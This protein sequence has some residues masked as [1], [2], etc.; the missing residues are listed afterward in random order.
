MQHTYL[1]YEC[2]DSFSL[3]ASTPSTTTNTTQTLAILS[4]SSSSSDLVISSAGSQCVAF[5]LRSGNPTR[6]Y[7]K[8]G[9]RDDTTN[10]GTGRALNSNECTCLDVYCPRAGSVGTKQVVLVSTGWVDGS[11]RIFDLGN[12]DE[13]YNESSITGKILKD[14]L[15]VVN[16]LLDS[17]DNDDEDIPEPLV[18][19]GHSNSPVTCVS[20]DAEK[21]GSRLASASSDGTI[22]IWDI[23]AETGLFRLIGHHK[24]IT[25]LAFIAPKSENNDGPSSFC[26]L[27]GLIS[28]SLDG[29][30]KVWDLSG[31][32][33]TQTV[34]GHRGEIW[35]SDAVMLRD[36][37]NKQQNRWRLITGS[38]DNQLRVYDIHPPKRATLTGEEE[39]DL[40]SD[41]A[42]KT[43]SNIDD[44][45]TY[46]GSVK[47]QTNE[48]T[49][50]VRFHS[51]SKLLAVSI[52]QSKNIEIYGIRSTEESERKRVRR[53]RR[54]REKQNKK[55]SETKVV[56][57]KGILDEE[58]D[59][60]DIDDVNND[61]HD[62]IAMSPEKICAS[63]E[64]YY[65]GTVRASHKVRSFAFSPSTDRAVGSKIIISLTTNALETHSLKKKFNKEDG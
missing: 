65:L 45:L 50:L 9:Y 62:D 26:L 44:V 60:Y 29:L 25:S 31:Q 51:K 6:P 54:R 39:K 41:D 27:D 11:V 15:G 30:V 32:C 43:T 55:S 7:A 64:F 19:N 40:K 10:V 1:R 35:T 36:N 22:V 34:A 49:A 13:N 38:S 57:K 21:S 18:L 47:R 28:T 61:Q 59:D 5:D 33:C 14:G 53:L 58:D 46:I 16:S 52:H 17:Y 2:A 56:K 42:I 24:T 12:E 23:I 4:P 3:A 20:F 63:D 37:K 8:I 48:R